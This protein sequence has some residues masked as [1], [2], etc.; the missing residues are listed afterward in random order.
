MDINTPFEMWEDE[1]PKIDNNNQKDNLENYNEID[2]ECNIAEDDDGFGG[3]TENSSSAKKKTGIILDFNEDDD[4]VKVLKP[5]VVQDEQDILNAA[6]GVLGQHSLENT[7]LSKIPFN[8][9]DMECSI[10]EDDDFGCSPKNE[11]EENFDIENK[12]LVNND[13]IVQES[14]QKANTLINQGKIEADYYDK[15]KKKHA[16]SNVKGSYNTHFHFSHDPETEMKDFNVG[17]GKNSPEGGVSKAAVSEL[18]SCISTMGGIGES[19]K[20]NEYKKLFEDFLNLSGFEIEKLPNKTIKLKDLYDDKNTEYICRNADD[21]LKTLHPF[22][23]DYC[24]TPLQIRTGKDLKDCKDWYSWY[25]NDIA[26]Q[27]PNCKDDI[28]YCDLMANHINDCELF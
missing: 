8:E 21:I 5:L 1:S 15:L 6:H 19:K 13:I 26:K 22:I 11:I 12:E 9:I 20:G 24:I 3:F 25:N 14:K 10:G 2:M 23:V 7:D 16:N 4:S 18:D 27:Y 17:V 28:K